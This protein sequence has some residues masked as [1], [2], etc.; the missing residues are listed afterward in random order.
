MSL[1][2]NTSIRNWSS[3]KA[4]R[5]GL[6]FAAVLAIL[7][8]LPQG[9]GLAATGT[10]TSVSVAHEAA[11]TTFTVTVK[12]PAGNAVT[13][14]TVSLMTGG[15]SLG[16]AFVN[17]EG[18]ATL[19]LDKVPA[20]AKQ[21]TAVYSGSTRFAASTSANIAAPEDTAPPTPDF[22][23]TANP[24]AM[25]LNAGQ[26]GSSVL[27]VSSI[28]AFSQSVTLSISGLPG[29]GTTS[30]T[31]TPSNVIPPAGGSATSTLQIQ[32]TAPSFATQSRLRE[33][34]AAHITYALA[35]PGALALLGIGALLKRGGNG[36]RLM[37]LVLLL[38][39]SV[40]GLTACSARYSY[41]HHPPEPNTGT[42]LGNFPLT[43]TAYSNNGGEVTSHT[44]TLTLTVQ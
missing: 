41:L 31:F 25:T 36:L 11:G 20:N 27:T 21:L 39:A 19:T 4:V 40:S 37:G 29:V 26:F 42:P 24:S 2:S 14:G 9:F 34:K 17:A 10:R 13:D 8:V 16:S 5:Y 22:S 6:Y 23:V 43:I 12:D 18:A 38:G 28:G 1:Q 15:Q 44:L 30:S 33:N 3:T 35:F 32:T 7:L